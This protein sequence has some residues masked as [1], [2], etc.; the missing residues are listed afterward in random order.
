M[1]KKVISLAVLWLLLSTLVQ[2]QGQ[3]PISPTGGTSPKQTKY[4]IGEPLAL[5]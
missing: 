2:A 4:G 3:P 5:S 1:S